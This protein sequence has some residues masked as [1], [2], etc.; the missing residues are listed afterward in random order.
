MIE[1]AKRKS[2]LLIEDFTIEPPAYNKTDTTQ[3]HTQH[4]D[5]STEGGLGARP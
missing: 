3:T 2:L 4:K 1:D 5:I